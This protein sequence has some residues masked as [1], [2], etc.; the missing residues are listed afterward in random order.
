MVAPKAGH[1][2]I[3]TEQARRRGDPGSSPPP[4]ALT[5]RISAHLEPQDPVLFARFDEVD[6]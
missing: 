6:K 3:K 1:K 4:H 5:L 2:K